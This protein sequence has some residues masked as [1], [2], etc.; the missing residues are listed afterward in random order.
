MR[1]HWE[2]TT[3]YIAGKTKTRFYSYRGCVVV[4]RVFWII[5]GRGE[6][7]PTHKDRKRSGRFRRESLLHEFFPLNFGATIF[8]LS[9]ESSA[10]STSSDSSSSPEIRFSV[11]GQK[12][13]STGDHTG[14]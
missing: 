12:D 13:R 14:Q 6:E 7:N 8:K 9:S 2:V 3:R 4:P 10:L 11:F 1:T 5:F